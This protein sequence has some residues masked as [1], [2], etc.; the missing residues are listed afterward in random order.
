MPVP[1]LCPL[2]AAPELQ[3][4]ELVLAVEKGNFLNLKRL[5]ELARKHGDYV[6]STFLRE[7]G[8]CWLGASR[9]IGVGG[10]CRCSCGWAGS[11]GQ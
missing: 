3:A 9:A 11:I 2:A 7:P 10:G 8:G 6:L 4:V 5:D 1:P